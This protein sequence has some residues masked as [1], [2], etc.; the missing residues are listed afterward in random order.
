MF[1][2]SFRSCFLSHCYWF[3][4]IKN[5]LTELGQRLKLSKICYSLFYNFIII[6][7]LL[8]FF[9]YFSIKLV[10]FIFSYR[11]VNNVTPYVVLGAFVSLYMFSSLSYIPHSIINNTSNH[12]ECIQL[13][14]IQ[15][16]F[17]LIMLIV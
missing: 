11:Y 7:A 15:Y 5:N 4:L 12:N 6:F 2:C 17:S 1:V 3:G 16:T 14:K 10:K 8:F 13:N 9:R